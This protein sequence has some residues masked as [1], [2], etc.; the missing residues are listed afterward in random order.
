MKVIF[1][2]DKC[3]RNIS[4]FA[5]GMF[6]DEVLQE[7]DGVVLEQCMI[8]DIWVYT[9]EELEKDIETN[10][11]TMQLLSDEIREIERENKK[12]KMLLE[13]LKSAE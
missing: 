5:K 4:N 6:S 10:M 1:S 9:Q 7:M 3:L 11:Q 13:K 2:K 12:L 8:C